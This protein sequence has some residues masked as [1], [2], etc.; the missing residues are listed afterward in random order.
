MKLIYC[1]HCHDV[2]K[3]ARLLTTCQ[4]GRSWGQYLEDDLH[5]VYG[6]VAVP[7]GF[8]NPSFVDALKNQPEEG[9]GERFEAFVIPK[10]CPTLR[11]IEPVATRRAGHLEPD[12]EVTFGGTIQKT[13]IKRGPH[14]GIQPER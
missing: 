6:G 5:A 7:L 2:R 8:T 11:K 3:L 9:L 10:K 14:R 1:P 13:G 12:E 4:C